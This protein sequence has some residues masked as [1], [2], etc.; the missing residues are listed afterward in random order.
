M[1]GMDEPVAELAA[2]FRTGT[3]LPDEELVRLTLAARSA[4]SRWEGIAAACGIITGQDL[5]G[6]GGRAAGAT[7]AEL[8]FSATQDTVRR[9]TGSRRRLPPLTWACPGCGQPVTDRAPAGR[10]VHVEHGHAPGCTRL[11]CDQAAED[12]RRREQIPGLIVDTEPAAGPVQR[13]RL[14]ER[15][16]DDCPRCG[17]HGGFNHLATVGGDWAAAICGHCYTDL[18][19]GITVTVKFYAARRPGFRPADD[20]TV[21]VIRQRHR[22]DYDYPDNGQQ[23]DWRLWW[24][25]SA[26]LAEDAHGS[27]TYDL[28]QI[29]RDEAEQIAA[30]LAAGHWP[31][32]AARLP[33][34]VSAY[35]Q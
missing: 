13:H 4:G 24:Q 10:P 27:C 28:P 23:L 15:I 33:W 16:T 31:P 3:K 34:V 30:G 26:M 2:H 12:A 25:F 17:W 32:D 21:A 19:P 14:R 29:S 8:L 6:L 35:P 5:G 9:L 1:P 20:K 11:T 7:G 22:S 18:H